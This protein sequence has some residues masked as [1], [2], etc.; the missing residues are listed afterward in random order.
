MS[1]REQVVKVAEKYVAKGKLDAAIKEYLK[2]LKEN[3]NDVSTLNRLG[4]LYARTSRIDEAVRLFTQIA[5]QYTE[6][7]FFVKAIAIY[8]K[9]IKLDPTRL[10]VYEHLAGLYHRQR[11]VNEARTQYQVLDDYYLKHSDAAAAINIF[12]KMGEL[13]PDNPSHHLRLAELYQQRQLWDKALRSYR[14]I[15]ELMLRHDR[16]DEAV[17]VYQRAIEVHSEDLVFIGDALTGLKEAGHTAAALRLLALAVS[18]NPH[19]ERVGRVAGLRLDAGEE[20][21]APVAPAHAEPVAPE[22]AARAT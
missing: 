18:A 21:D 2:V 22:P 5:Q 4:D 6:D 7:G 16:V 3:P 1:T 10:Q 9:I 14:T 15:A 8:K 11:L 19:A 12:V 20:L 17:R 13:E